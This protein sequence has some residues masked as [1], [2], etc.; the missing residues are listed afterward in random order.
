[1]NDLLF[2]LAR[3]A[4]LQGESVD[5]VALHEAVDAAL[6]AEDPAALLLGVTRNLQV[7]PPRWLKTPDAAAVPALLHDGRLGWAVL[8]GLNAKGQWIGERFDF[9]L[10][11]WT[12]IVVS[13][14]SGS[15]IARMR[16]VKP[17]DP[18][19]SAVYRLIRHEFFAHKKKLFDAAL[20]GLLIN[21]LAIATS[22]Y[23][24]QV[25]DRVVP[26]GASQTLL[27]L[28]M[29]V[30][31]AILFELMAKHVRSGLHERLADQV[32]QRL[33][34]TVYT[35]F[36]SIRL[37]QLPG[38]VGALAAQLRG[39]E[40]VRGFLVS[41][42]L[43]LLVDA[44]FALIFLALMAW[45]TGWLALIPGVFFVLAVI[46]GLYYRGRVDVFARKAT[47]AGHMK[48]GLL[49]ETVEGAETIKSGQGGWRMLSRW[50]K[51]ADEARDQEL[52]MRNIH[53]SSQHLMATFQQIS[54]V[55]LVAGGALLVSRGE[56]TM[57]GLIACS[58]LSGRVL[59]PVGMIPAQLVKWAETRAALQSL[60]QLWT[61]QDDHHGCEQPIVPSSVQGHYR[62]QDVSFQYGGNR[63]LDVK[64][65]L[66]RP[67]EKIGI[68]GPV[69]GGKTTFLRLLSGMYKPQQGRILLDDID[70]SHLSKPVLTEHI[71]YLQQEGRLFAGTLRDN[72]VLGLLDPGDGPI[73][74]A[75]RLTGLMEA[76]IVAHPKGLLQEIHEG[77]SGLSGGQRQLVNLTRVFLRRPSIWLLDEPTASMDRTLELQV[78]HALKRSLTESDTLVLVTHKTEMLEIV[79]RLILIAGNQVVMDGPKALVMQRLQAGPP[80]GLGNSQKNAVVLA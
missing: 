9:D 48:T 71:G 21:T 33:S 63:A 52:K 42:T 66:I 16:L 31:F 59:A 60:D 65:M 12:E 2:S 7:R 56:L 6:R 46:V 5:R 77:G 28:T 61:L 47:Q 8:R 1:V 54:Y 50:M 36:L 10:K 49:V 41:V 73:L 15:L 39:Y 14:W 34:R 32:D 79:D 4:E 17:Y 29:G 26:T 76:V 80:A 58:I 30:V 3:L 78:T 62:L 51:T 13:D 23:S 22:F 53:E 27:V 19:K 43:Q 70:I 18:A 24:M 64:Q 25:Y 35:R 55:L 72:L 74:A 40:T 38:R 44:P 11:K 68:I 57:G 67:G 45:I 37:D 20:G 69:G 75:A